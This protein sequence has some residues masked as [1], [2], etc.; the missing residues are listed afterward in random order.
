MNQNKSLSI[1]QV[2]PS[3]I[4]GGVETGTVDIARAL[5]QSGHRAIV[6]SSGGQMVAKLNDMGATH[7]TL[8]VHSK[9]PIVMWQ[10]AQ[11]IKQLIRNEKIDVVHARSRAPAWSC[12]WATR[13]EQTPYITTFHGTYGH[14][15]RIKRWYNSVMLKSDI[16]IAVSNFIA[17]HI[18]ENYTEQLKTT[19]LEHAVKV[20][21]RGIDIDKFNPASTPSEAVLA[22]RKAWDIPDNNIVIMLPGRLTRWKGHTFLIEAL[23]KLEQDN[24]TCLLVGDNKDKDHYFE[25]LK[26]LIHR[27]Q[28]DTAVKMVGGCTNMP[29]AYSLADIVVS[30]S[31][32]P[33][34]FGRVVC[35]AQAM[36]CLVVATKHGGSLENIAHEQQHLMCR[37]SD[38]EAMANSIRSGLA[39]CQ[40]EHAALKN[41]IVNASREHIKHNFTLEL[42]CRDTL[43]VYNQVLANKG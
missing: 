5:V 38:S 8:P 41:S 7:I 1:M 18:A 21:H 12:Y 13:S 19:P 42:M 3:L 43:S 17:E 14:K 34:A 32:D 37:V 23:A 2:L 27:H 31:T 22:L 16:T 28:L 24:I 30:A 36:K 4:S 15:S 26:A 40:T 33:E 6:V 20:I 25:E 39:L 29:A 35:E 10:N 9:N 11:K